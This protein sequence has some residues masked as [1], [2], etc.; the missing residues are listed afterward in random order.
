MF[1]FTGRAAFRTRSRYLRRVWA[2]ERGVVVP[3]PRRPFVAW[4]IRSTR[5]S[6][7]PSRRRARLIPDVMFM[8]FGVRREVDGLCLSSKFLWSMAGGAN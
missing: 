3:R 5:T 1:E 6:L 7:V 2:V 4:R 8:M